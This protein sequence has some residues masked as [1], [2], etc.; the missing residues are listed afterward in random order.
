MIQTLEEFRRKILMYSPSE[1]QQVLLATELSERLHQGQFRESGDPYFVHPLQVA[2]ILVDLKMD[3]ATVTA[4]LLH[5]VL[6]DTAKSRTDL[7]KEFGRE[8]EQL[9]FG[10]TK[11]STVK[12]KHKNVQE[13]ETIRKMLFAMVKDIRVILIKLADKLHNMRT[14]EFKNEE[15]RR[16]QIAQE[17]LD[18]YAPLAGRLGISWIKDELEDLALKNLHRE[19]YDQIKAFVSQKREVRAGY[20]QRVEAAILEAGRH[21]HVDLEVEARA[22]HFY[23]IYQK[24]K[25][26]S[27]S[28]DEIYDLLGLRILCGSDSEC[29]T[30]LG[31]VHRLWPPIEGR[32]K[33]YIA[34]PKANRYQSLHTTVLGFDGKLLEIQIRTGDMNQTA[35]YGIAAHWLYK[36]GRN[37]NGGPRHDLAIISRVRDLN[38]LRITSGEFLEEIKREILKDSIYV[39]TPKGEAI[40]LPKGA[41]AI[42]FAYH[43]HTEIGNHTVGAKADGNIIPLREPLKNTQVIEIL[44]SPNAHPHVNW[45]RYVRTARAR[46]KIRHWLNKHDDSLIIERSIVARKKEQPPPAPVQPEP[47][48]AVEPGPTQILDP[49]KVGVRIGNERNMMIRFAGCCNPTI[50]D[51][52][53]GYI[54]RGRGII[55]HRRDCSNVKHINDFPER[56]I[57]VEWETV[58]PRET[59]RFRVVAR[60]TSDLFSEIEGA[61]RKFRGHLIEGRVDENEAGNLEAF[62]T[63]ELDRREDFKTVMKSIRTIPSVMNITDASLN[64]YTTARP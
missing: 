37:S 14:L 36:E 4:A 3:A 25:K 54:S 32:F 64:Q 28:I 8:V 31:I 13:T 10:V 21:E 2:D 59:R 40:Q 12:A 58:S 23:S 24:M 51:P 52:I 44:T 30:V 7:R 18:I 22:K 61:V 27:K 5:D 9:V 63:M 15:V 56:T 11:I 33:D 60:R 19:S 1:Q 6:E 41:T 16:R 20:L 29:Y 53:V 62:F 34:M 45:L 46:S 17:C 39:F 38:G 35:E 48:T 50:G 49:T 42:D 26:R 57:E 43:I 55:V 47:E